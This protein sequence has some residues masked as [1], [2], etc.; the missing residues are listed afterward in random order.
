MFEWVLNAP[1]V[2]TIKWHTLRKSG[3]LEKADFGPLQKADT[4]RKFTVLVKITF[5]TN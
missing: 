2:L 4:M 1:L 5:M 3:P